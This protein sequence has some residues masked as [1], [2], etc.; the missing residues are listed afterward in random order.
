MAK[1]V[2]TTISLT[3]RISTWVRA[4]AKRRDVPEGEVIRGMLDF[5]IDLAKGHAALCAVA[6]AKPIKPKRAA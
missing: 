6:A 5:A 1:M 4:E 2:P 3:E